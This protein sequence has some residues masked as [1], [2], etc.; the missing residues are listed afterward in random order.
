MGASVGGLASE[1]SPW[2]A[3]ESTEGPR[4]PPPLARSPVL[5]SLPLAPPSPRPRPPARGPWE[6]PPLVCS[7]LISHVLCWERR[8]TGCIPQW[9][10]SF[11]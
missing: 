8:R 9:G 10:S 3:V 5:L 4:P 11:T 1:T 2:L 7:Q 6:L